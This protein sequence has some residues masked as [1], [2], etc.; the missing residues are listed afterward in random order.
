[1]PSL[2]IWFDSIFQCFPLLYILQRK[3]DWG[4]MIRI[5]TITIPFLHQCTQFNFWIKFQ[6]LHFSL[7]CHLKGHLLLKGAEGHIW[8]HICVHFLHCLLK[9]I[10]IFIQLFKIEILQSIGNKYN[11][12]TRGRFLRALISKSDEILLKYFLDPSEQSLICGSGRVTE[13]VGA[14]DR[15]VSWM[16]LLVTSPSP[17]L[18]HSTPTLPSTTCICDAIIGSNL[19]LQTQDKVVSF[20]FISLSVS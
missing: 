3:L 9:T 20:S 8:R 14:E 6:I 15:R 17:T 12:P 18:L 4:S 13:V 7:H 11:K 16:L 1:M 19:A 5:R 2:L 10:N